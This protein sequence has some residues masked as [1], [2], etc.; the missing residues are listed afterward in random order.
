MLPG[1]PSG[2]A[3]LPNLTGGA[4]GAATSGNSGATHFGN[5]SVGISLNTVLLVLG[6]AGAVWF[7]FFRKK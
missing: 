1:M 4:G 3:S 6:A 7:F 5:V 2:G